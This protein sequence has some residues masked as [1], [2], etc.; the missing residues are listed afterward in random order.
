MKSFTYCFVSLVDG[1]TELIVAYWLLLSNTLYP[2]CFKTR[3][4]YLT[5]PTALVLSYKA[6]NIKSVASSGVNSFALKLLIEELL[7]KN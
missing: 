5:I 1:S 3:F 4:N 2:K 6:Y 7:L